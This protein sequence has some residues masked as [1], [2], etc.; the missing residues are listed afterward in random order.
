MPPEQRRAVIEAI[1]QSKLLDVLYNW[2][3]TW[4]RDD[5]REPPGDW[6]VWML[7]S[8]R[9]AGKTRSG[10]E[11]VRSKVEGGI[12]Q[13]LA[14]ISPTAAD[15]RDVMVEGESGILATARPDFRPTYMPS[16]RRVEWPNGARAWLYSG[17]EPDRLRGP[18]HDAAWCDE[19][20]SWRHPETWDM[21]LLGLRLGPDPRAIVTTT[22][23]PTRLVRQ[24]ADSPKTVTTVASTFANV[25][26]LASQF[27][28]DIVTTYDGT[29]LG[30]QELYGEIIEDIL[31]AL[32]NRALVDS[33]RLDANERHDLREQLRRVVV[34][35]D[36]AVTSGENADETGIVVVGVDG[37]NPAHGYTLADE[38]GRYTPR[39]WAK[40]VVRLYHDWRADRVVAEV[41]NGGDLVESILR[42][43]D[44]NVSYRKVTASRGKYVRA[45]PVS[46]LWE[47]GRA[48]N[49]GLFGS[50]EDQ[51]CNFTP[52]LDRAAF[53]S[54]DRVDAL[55]WGYTF[56]MVKSRPQRQARSRAG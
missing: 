41:N 33:T 47:Q 34:A 5:Q 2:E 10:A 24:I 32:W 26:F 17:E 19:L 43:E 36:P 51:M 3:G 1:P 55:V 13:R 8:G 29:H 27:M 35:V 46:A 39:E 49:V 45:E 16:K 31:G 22:P 20:A 40:K 9:G 38:S 4:A 15:C 56:L 28:D 54:P 23:R 11:W 44:P 21:L 25:G 30:R 48:H 37:R 52:D 53:G 7:R 14:L 42:T 6:R 50:L 12:Y 18:Q